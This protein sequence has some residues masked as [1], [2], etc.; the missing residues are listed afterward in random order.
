VRWARVRDLY[1]VTAQIAVAGARLL[2]EGST[3][4]GVL[5]PSQ[6]FD[7]DDLLAQICEETGPA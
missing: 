5:T 1:G 4:A 2:A 6:L 7:P 3:P